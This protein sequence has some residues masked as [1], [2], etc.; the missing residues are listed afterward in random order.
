MVNRARGPLDVGHPAE[1]HVPGIIDGKPGV[2]VDIERVVT[3][4]TPPLRVCEY[5]S[6]HAARHLVL[7][8]V[9]AVLG[10]RGGVD[11]GYRLPPVLV[12][13]VPRWRDRPALGVGEEIGRAAR[14]RRVQ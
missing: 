4:P 5:G 6:A 8:A 3:R 14:R 12:V 1:E 9:R 13:Y 10:L 11:G 2:H 7:D